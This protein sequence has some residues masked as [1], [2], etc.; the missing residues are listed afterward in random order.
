MAVGNEW[1]NGYLEAILDAGVKLREQRGAAAVQ[2]LPPLLPAPAEDAAAA[3]AATAAT[4]SP[5]RYFVEEV[6]SRFD[7]R[8]LHKTWTKVVAMR[9]SQE[10]NNRLE[11]LC[12]RI[13]N[14]ARRKKQLRV[15][16]CVVLPPPA[17]G[18]AWPALGGR[19]H[20]R[21][22]EEPPAL[23]S[24]SSR[25]EEL[26]WGWKEELAGMCRKKLAGVGRKKS[27]LALGRRSR[28][29]REK[30]ELASVGEELVGDAQMTQ[31]DVVL[32]AG[33]NT[34]LR[35]DGVARNETIHV[36]SGMF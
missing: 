13:W 2:L 12:W 18:E 22:K 27:S 8:D 1:I 15:V 26:H 23:G 24:K 29:R 36:F 33:D 21:E 9:N 7:D 11:N 10:R 20:R 6:V 16:H 5:T 31:T 32:W 19:A 25:E 14:V 28:R 3:V 34:R 17:W 30:E 35:K 4:Y